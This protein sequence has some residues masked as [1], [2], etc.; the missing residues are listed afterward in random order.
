[1]SAYANNM[2]LTAEMGCSRKHKEVGEKRREELVYP[3]MSRLHIQKEM[4]HCTGL[5]FYTEVIG[6]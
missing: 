5:A 2:Y 3:P 4:E 6:I 1:M